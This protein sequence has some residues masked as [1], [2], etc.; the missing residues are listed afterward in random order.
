MKKFI[1]LTLVLFISLLTP[2]FAQDS[3]WYVGGGLGLSKG[4][5]GVSGLTGT[6]A[7]DDD[8]E[9][10]KIFTG[11]KFDKF[12]G[13][14]LAYVDFGDAS[15]T[16]NT[17]DTF[18]INGSRYQFLTDGVT[19]GAEAKSISIEGVYYIPL[20][21]YTGKESHKFFIPYLKAGAHFWD[22]EY[23]VV[24][25][26]IDSRTADDDGFGFVGGVGLNLNII[27]NFSIRAE[28]ER[29]FMEEDIDFF[30]GNLV[31]NF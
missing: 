23:S 13:I 26:S 19:L 11:Y 5:T 31:F 16:G 25:S 27:K 7:L 17:G 12:I 8:G 28:W 30:S 6:A 21:Y 9:G 22:V 24:A 4:D 20:D 2:A 29:F 15:L 18:V 3:Q 14:E 10:F 1:F